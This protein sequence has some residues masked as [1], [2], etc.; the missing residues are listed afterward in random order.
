MVQSLAG[1]SRPSL[2][3][4]EGSRDSDR[5]RSRRPTAVRRSSRP[6]LE[7]LDRRVLLDASPTLAALGAADPGPIEVGPAAITAAGVP[8]GRLDPISDTGVSAIDNITTDTTPTFIGQA[9][10]GATV[11]LTAF[12]S[13]SLFGPIPLGQTVTGPDGAWRLTSAP[14]DVG[15]YSVIARVDDLDG[16][17][18]TITIAP[19][20][21]FGPLVIA[22][23]APRIQTINLQPRLGRLLVTYADPVAGL[24]LATLGDPSAISLVRLR[25]P[26]RQPLA[27]TAVATN[28]SA[29][30]NAPQTVTFTFNGG[31]QLPRG[32][33]GLTIRSGTVTNTL[34]LPLDGE[35]RG[36][37]PT[38]DGASGGNFIGALL[39]GTDGVY[40]GLPRPLGGFFTPPNRTPRSVVLRNR[41]FRL[42][43]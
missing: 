40:F 12:P 17:S 27:V 11:T 32:F 33:Y 21:A 28:P 14:L 41:S 42:N 3:T 29:P 5:G 2:G 16:Q 19:S 26:G 18:I 15:S 23:D 37:F 9:D 31:R 1:S 25:G 24:N 20:G 22:S 43:L 8:T 10:P 30:F 13:G 35:F 39:V 4:L 36:T 7:S 38:G 34:G 6:Q